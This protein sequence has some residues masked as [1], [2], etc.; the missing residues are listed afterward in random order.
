MTNQNAVNRLNCCPKGLMWSLSKT[1]ARKT[2]KTDPNDGTFYLT[3]PADGAA[4]YVWDNWN[5]FFAD[6][7]DSNGGFVFSGEV[8]ALKGKLIGGKFHNEQSEYRG[9]VYDHIRLRWTCPADDIRNGK[10][11]KMP[12]DVLINTS[13]S[14]QAGSNDF[15]DIPEAADEDI[16]F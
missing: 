8:A 2:T 5:T 6:L 7:E 15:M 1:P 13:A 11:G 12:N 14:P 4:Q 3:V 9:A 10:A 16:P